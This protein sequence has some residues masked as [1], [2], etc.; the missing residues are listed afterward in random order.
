M[1]STSA[2]CR[3][4]VVLG[5]LLAVALV[6]RPVWTTALAGLGL[7]AGWAAPL[8]LAHRRHRAEAP[9]LTLQPGEAGLT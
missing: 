9:A 1:P 3:T 7:V 2:I 6:G 4:V 8:M 5:Y